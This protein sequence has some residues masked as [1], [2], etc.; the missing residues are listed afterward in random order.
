MLLS[1]TTVIP[2]I[3]IFANVAIIT[4]IAF[5]FNYGYKFENLK[6]IGVT[7]WFLII[8][9]LVNYFRWGWTF[10]D[11]SLFFI[12]GGVSLL[13]L[14]IHLEKKRSIVKNKTKEMPR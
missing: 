13:C 5:G 1:K 7:N 2:L 9:L 14:G 4:I 8:Y 6:I 10:M 12:F 11:K 3:I